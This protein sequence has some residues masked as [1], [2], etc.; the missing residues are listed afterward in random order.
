MKVAEDLVLP[1][2]ASP[3]HKLHLSKQALAQLIL[4]GGDL[5][6]AI[7]LEGMGHGILACAGAWRLAASLQFSACPVQ[8]PL[9][10]RALDGWGHWSQCLHSTNPFFHDCRAAGGTRTLMAFLD[11]YG[12][13]THEATSPRCQKNV[14]TFSRT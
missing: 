6:P 8:I 9:I 2:P 12:M 4:C 5:V 7:V 10:W 14:A 1:M 13:L 3:K 11:R